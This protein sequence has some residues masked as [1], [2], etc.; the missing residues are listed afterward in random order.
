[1]TL[2]VPVCDDGGD[3]ANATTYSP[4]TGEVGGGGGLVLC[5]G[6]VT[7]VAA[8]EVVPFNPSMLD[9]Q[10]MSLMFGVGFFILVPV[11][12]ASVGIKYMLSLFKG[13][14]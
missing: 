11:W 13:D 6:P 10:M 12:A 8:S 2:V 1:M 4:V 14:Q 9:P 5:N 3:S 7:Y